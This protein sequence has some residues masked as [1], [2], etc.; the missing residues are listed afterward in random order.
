MITECLLLASLHG[1]S[2]FL[3]LEKCLGC[4][5]HLC[6]LLCDL[7]QH[8]G[9]H[10]GVSA[11][12]RNSNNSVCQRLAV[13]HYCRNDL[14]VCHIHHSQ[15]LDIDGLCIGLVQYL[16]AGTQLCLGENTEL[17]KQMDS[18]GSSQSIYCCYHGRNIGQ[19]SS[20]CFL[21][22]FP[23]ITVAIENNTLV[24]RHIFLDQIMDCHI[25][26]FRTFQT[27]CSF[28]ERLCHNGIQG[29]VGASDG[30]LASHHTE[31]EF[32]SCKGKR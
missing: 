21:F 28:A 8:T 9:R 27:V 17:F 1:G 3:H 7:L 26:I 25:E 15:C 12:F 32:I 18:L 2:L 19:S 13:F 11:S 6:Q 14:L 16:R 29:G 22:P 30:I 24:L 5:F 31:F 23:G 10:V 20:G 4:L